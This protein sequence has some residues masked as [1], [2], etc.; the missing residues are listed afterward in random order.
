VPDPLVGKI[1]RAAERRDGEGESGGKG[2]KSSR[3][4][5]IVL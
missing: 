4:N 2:A 1:K 3:Q 5:P